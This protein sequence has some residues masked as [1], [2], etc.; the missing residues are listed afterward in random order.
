MVLSQSLYKNHFRDESQSKYLQ[1]GD[2]ITVVYQGEIETA[3]FVR[4]SWTCF[5]YVSSLVKADLNQDGVQE[6]YIEAWGFLSGG[7]DGRLVIRDPANQ[8]TL[9]YGIW[10]D[11]PLFGVSD[12]VTDSDGRVFLYG[13]DDGETVA[14]AEILYH[15]EEGYFYIEMYD[16]TPQTPVTTEPVPPETTPEGI[17]ILYGDEADRAID[18]DWNQGHS[19][20][21]EN[22]HASLNYNWALVIKMIR[23]ENAIYE[24]LVLTVGDEDGVSGFV[25]DKYRFVVTIEE[26]NFEIERF[27]LYHKVNEGY[28]R[29][30]LGADYVLFED[31]EE[32]GVDVWLRIYDDDTDELVYYAWFTDYHYDGPYQF[33]SCGGP[34]SELPSYAGLSTLYATPVSGP[35]GYEKL[36]DGTMQTALLTSDTEG[37]VWKYD[38]AVKAV[39]YLLVGAGDDALHPERVPTGFLIFMFPLRDRHR[40]SGEY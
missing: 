7:Y 6:E 19:I 5:G 30:D 9:M 22:H 13:Y 11:S 12:I 39:G 35:E 20:A 27:S 15:K 17:D 31:P 32:D 2:E 36:F 29:M 18:P 28:I 26:Q 14:I 8:K 10:Q 33:P 1:I 34:P 16:S 25:D 21:F 24:D 40:R 3:T 37:I 4:F 38:K 23:S